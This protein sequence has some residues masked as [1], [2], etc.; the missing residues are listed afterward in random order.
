[1]HERCNVIVRMIVVKIIHISG[2]YRRVGNI[3]QTEINTKC[4][5]PCD[6]ESLMRVILSYTTVKC[7]TSSLDSKR[8]ER[9]AIPL[10]IT[11]RLT[12]YI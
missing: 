6:H 4:D 5:H 9:P 7:T 8:R 1:M 12:N 2:T 3:V 11:S 10:S